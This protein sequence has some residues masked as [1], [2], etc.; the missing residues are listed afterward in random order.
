[1]DLQ[2]LVMTVGLVRATA[3]KSE[4]IRLLSELLRQ[5][6][7]RETELAAHYLCGT[8]P[9]GKIGAGWAVLHKAAVEGPAVGERLSLFDVDLALTAVAAD[10]GAGSNER[11]TMQLARLF[12]RATPEERQFLAR[13][14][15]GEIRQGALEGLLLDAIA[16]AAARSA[17]D[18][19][20]AFMY[21]GNIGEIAR[22]ALVEGSEGLARFSLQLFKPISPMLAGSAEDVDDALQRLEE[23]AFEYKLDGVRI[24]VHKGGDDVRIFTRQ[25]QDVT[26]RLPDIVEWARALP[27]REA[28][29]DGEALA[30]RPDGRPHPFQVTMRR[31]G[32]NKD[33]AVLRQELPLSPF[34]FDLLYLN[35]GSLVDRPYRERSRQLIETVSGAAVP[36]L[37]THEPEAA[38]RFFQQALAAGHEGIMAKSSRALYQA[39]ERGAQWLKVKQAATLDLV[40]VAA[41][42]GNGRRT[43]WLSNLHL[44][45]RDGQSGQLVMLGKTF[46]GLTDKMLRWQTEQ[47]LSL[48]THRDGHTVYVR[49]ALVVE[50][51][52]SD[53]QESPRYP[54]GLALRFARVKRYRP[55]KSVEEAD[56]LLTVTD[57][58]SRQRA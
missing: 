56:S 43:G 1:M 16:K 55:D 25:L 7:G 46:K 51:A 3:K 11:R 30:L 33:I 44:G 5:A 15:I 52:F 23:A 29:L 34:M 54:G 20:Q 50:I 58:F 2:Q 37:N 18:V 47:L 42:W 38:R 21:S 31:L 27:A 19:R 22:V 14:V 26:E 9:Q 12:H 35:G 8:L 41:E 17:A 6:E 57:L 53:V 39:G 24:Q 45:A 48:E 32:R 10:R 49:P 36:R 28:L 40:I 13:L 4:K